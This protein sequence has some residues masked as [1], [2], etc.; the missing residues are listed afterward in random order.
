MQNI[1][2]SIKAN[3]D[4]KLKQGDIIITEC[5]GVISE[6]YVEWYNAKTIKEYEEE[7]SDANTIEKVIQVQRPIKY[8]TIYDVPETLDS[9]ERKFLENIARP[10]ANK[11]LYIAKFPIYGYSGIEYEYIHIEMASESINLPKF[12]VGSMYKGMERGK[13]YTLEHLGIV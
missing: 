9:V 2:E 8:K 6:C 4:L 3:K 10:F 11:I 1:K 7:Q 5:G 12:E 13:Q